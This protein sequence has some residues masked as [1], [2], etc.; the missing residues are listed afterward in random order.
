MFLL[1]KILKKIKMRLEE[2]NKKIFGNSFAENTSME[3][4]M[5]KLNQFMISEGFDQGKKK[6][7]EKLHQDQENLS[8]QEEIFWR[9]KFRV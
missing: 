5:Q 8:K 6:V 2:W 9:Q 4:K 3:N 1:H 7:V